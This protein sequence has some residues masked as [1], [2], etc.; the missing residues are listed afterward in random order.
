MLRAY[1]SLLQDDWSDHIPILELVYNSIKN[2]SIGF[3]LVQ[4]IYTQLGPQDILEQILNLDAINPGNSKNETME[5]WLEKSQNR[6]CNAM[7]LIRN[8]TTIQKKYYD[9]HHSTLPPYKVGNFVT[10]R[11]D[12]YPMAIIHH[13][14]L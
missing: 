14:K 3:A 10:L 9:Q 4:L 2:M 13:N 6:L 5:E 8:V 1:I 7:E 12:L 11:L